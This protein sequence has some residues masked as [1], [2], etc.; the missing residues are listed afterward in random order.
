MPSILNS[1]DVSLAGVPVFR[2]LGFCSLS[3]GLS[4]PKIMSILPLLS[5]SLPSPLLCVLCLMK[6]FCYLNF[7]LVLVGY[8]NKFMFNMP[9]LLCN[10]YIKWFYRVAS[11]RFCRM[12]KCLTTWQYSVCSRKN[13]IYHRFLKMYILS[14]NICSLNKHILKLS[15]TYIYSF[16]FIYLYVFERMIEGNREEGEGSCRLF[17]NLCC[18]VFFVWE[19]EGR[20]GGRE[21]HPICLGEG[22]SMN[23]VPW[24]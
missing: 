11:T 19:G 3:Q 10:I 20:M 18:F 1:S 23:E 21:T 2:T 7:F 9:I 5:S 13:I 17:R 24:R 4:F 22:G 12:P 14:S 15:N 8:G 16:K 6:L